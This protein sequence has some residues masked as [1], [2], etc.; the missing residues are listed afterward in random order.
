M[1][2]ITTPANYFHALRRQLHREFRKPLVIM[3]PKALLRHPDCKSRLAEF[4][5]VPDDALIQ[6]GAALLLRGLVLPTRC[7]GRDG[8]A[9]G[10]QPSGRVGQPRRGRPW[11]DSVSLCPH[12]QGV[13]F[14]RLIMDS[15]AKDRSPNPPKEPGFKRLIFCSGKIYYDLAAARAKQGKEGDIAICRIEQL[16]P[17][18]FDLVARELRR[19]PNAEIM[20]CQ[21]EPMNMGAFYHVVPRINSIIRAEG[22]KTSGRLEYAGRAPSASTATGFGEVHQ[23]EQKQLVEQAL[24]LGFRFHQV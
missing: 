10:G 22:R 12:T 8:L 17:F 9:L 4:D 3:S 21:E 5:D 18:P 11:F 24:D 19:Y 20:W 2:N 6:V 15:S 23:H 13:R 14:K 7:L 1:C 16:A